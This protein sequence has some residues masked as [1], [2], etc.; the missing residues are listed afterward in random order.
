[1][2]PRLRLQNLLEG[3]PADRVPF[4]PAVYEHKAA[5]VGLTPSEM[6]RDADL[7]ERAIVREV[8]VYDADM[9]V[10]GCDVY[11]VEAEATGCE[12]FYPGSN[13]VPTISRR[14][15]EANGDLS[16]LSLP[17][18][19]KDGRMPLHI[20]VG[21]RI[22]R[23]FG[24]ERLVR[25]ALSAPFSIAAELVGS[26]QIL[27]A[28]IDNPAWAGKLL[29]FTKE[30]VKSYG[31]AFIE[32]GLGVILFDSHAAPPL[33]SPELYRKIILPP[34]A[35]VIDYFR[36]ALGVPLVPYIMGG[37]TAPL[38]EELILTGSNNILCDYKADLRFF[39]ERLRAEPILLRANLDPGFLRAQP[40]DRIKAKAHDLLAVGL[41]YP[42]FIMGTGILPYDISPE[43]VV[44]VRQ[45]LEEES[46]SG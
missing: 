12:I 41:R 43:K 16:R 1:M 40:A 15:L 8:E 18:P 37:N 32:Q 39:V 29:D 36:R 6:C 33:T 10:V 38:L 3:K 20:E 19:E 5:L 21:R 28:L 46:L 11:N 23:R 7:F 22:Q 44:A 45:A 31:R 27:M 2:M 30:I 24:E 17:N 14:P 25:G 9:L 35:E 42:R 26:T 13:D 4:C 34:T